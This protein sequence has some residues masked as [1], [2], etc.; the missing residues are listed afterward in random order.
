MEI[1]TRDDLLKHR[2][3]LAFY[4][5]Y[6]FIREVD[7]DLIFT[8][9]LLNP[10]I[11]SINSEE[12]E[13]K[14]CWIEQYRHLFIIKKLAW[15]SEYFSFPCYNIDFI[16][17]EHDDYKV[18]RDAINLFVSTQLPKGSYF[19][20]NIP[21]EDLVLTKAISSNQF[22]LVESRLHYFI[23]INKNISSVNND[24][25]LKANI[26]DI[27]ILKAIAVKMRNKFDRVHADSTFSDEVADNYL[28]KFAEESVKGFA[29]IV[30]KIIDEN[31]VPYGFLASN[32]PVNICT[33]LVSKLVLAAVDSSVHS[34]KLIELLKEMMF[35]LSLK[36]SDYLT[37]ITQTSNIPAIRVWE[38]AGF[39]LFK[40]TNLFS[41][42]YD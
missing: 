27:P 1:I 6:R 42:K 5:N 19:T 36:N 14:T 13:V 35:Q 32:Y 15:D 30:L 7:V 17:F 34:G 16:L 18:L 22:V 29:D 3:R 39:S 38:K 4:N 20:I 9:T 31:K 28:A 33:K 37:T 41:L 23:R 11:K 21:S 25:I 12:V 40:V 10:L 26:S 24:S 8:D 2:D